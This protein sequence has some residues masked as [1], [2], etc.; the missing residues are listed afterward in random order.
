MLNRFSIE[1]KASD[2]SGK[3]LQKAASGI[4]RDRSFRNLP[5]SLKNRYFSPTP[6]GM[7][8]TESLHKTVQFK[9]S[10]PSLAK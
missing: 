1:I 2:A 3:A 8:I 10:Q 9:K 7:A 6:S 4:Y 5:E